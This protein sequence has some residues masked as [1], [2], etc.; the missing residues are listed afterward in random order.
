VEIALHEPIAQTKQAARRAHKRARRH[1]EDAMDAVRGVDLHEP[2]HAAK[3]VAKRAA[4]RT[5]KR[6]AASATVAAGRATRQ[7]TARVG[8]RVVRVG[9]GALVAGLV[10]AVI[11]VVVRRLLAPPAPEV[12]GT[13]RSEWAPAN[14]G[15]GVP[16][17]LGP[18][19]GDGAESGASQGSVAA[20]GE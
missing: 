16:D 8:R 11:V 15:A 14:V 4:K 12:A 5:A 9:T 3:T 20:A 2:T 17:P 10:M 13:D 7:Q 6:A 18:Q 1:A 19:P